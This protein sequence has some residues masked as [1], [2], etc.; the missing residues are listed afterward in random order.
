MYIST[1]QGQELSAQVSPEHARASLVFARTFALRKV[2]VC[3]S[4][5]LEEMTKA[6]APA[7]FG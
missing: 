1:L 2:S 6:I 4:V 3:T 5:A 7:P